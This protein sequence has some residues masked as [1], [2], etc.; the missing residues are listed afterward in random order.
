MLVNKHKSGH[1][2]TQ[3]YASMYVNYLSVR[4]R[5]ERGQLS[6]I[7]FSVNPDLVVS[8]PLPVINSSALSVVTPECDEK[9]TPVPVVDLSCPATLR[10]SYRP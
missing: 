4:T 8:V 5:I 1:V 3:L 10:R 9:Q 6:Q 2:A 7:Q